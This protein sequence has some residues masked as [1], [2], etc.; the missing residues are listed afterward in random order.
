MLLGP[1]LGSDDDHIRWGMQ[2]CAV[3]SRSSF[4]GPCIYIVVSSQAD[5]TQ[6]P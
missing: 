1:A 4:Q 3:G 5:G 2:T 6:A